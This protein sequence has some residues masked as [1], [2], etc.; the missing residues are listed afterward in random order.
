[1]ASEMNINWM[2]KHF[3]VFRIFPCSSIE[4]HSTCQSFHFMFFFW[5]R[6][7]CNM[8]EWIFMLQVHS[9]VRLEG[10]QKESKRERLF[11]NFITSRTSFFKLFFRI[12]FSSSPFHLRLLAR[13]PPNWFFLIRQTTSDGVKKEQNESKHKRKNVLQLN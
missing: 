4:N 7:E 2:W 5:R 11:M 13:H 1:M 6:A 9:L 12:F 10:L 3:L 8:H